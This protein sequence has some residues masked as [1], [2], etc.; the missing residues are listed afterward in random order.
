MAAG[1]R[2]RV[3]DGCRVLLSP[4]RAHSS[5]RVGDSLPVAAVRTELGV[6]SIFL[7]PGI[8]DLHW[9]MLKMRSFSDTHLG[10]KRP[11]VW[12]MEAGDKNRAADYVDRVPLVRY[13]GT[14][15]PPWG[16]HLHMEMLYRSGVLQNQDG[17][18]WVLCANPHLE[19]SGD[20]REWMPELAI[21]WDYEIEERAGDA[22]FADEVLDHGPFILAS[23]YRDGWYG[24]HFLQHFGIDGLA[25]LLRDLNRT[26]RVLLTGAWWDRPF[27]GDLARLSGVS[28]H[29]VG[30][31]TCPQLL[32]ILRRCA[33]YVGH[34]AGNGIMAAHFRR[35]TA[36]LWSSTKFSAP[37]FDSWVRP[38]DNGTLYRAVDVA[39]YS[40]AAEVTEHLRGAM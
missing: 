3:V 35:P 9:L 4:Y 20:F 12:L 40:V 34:A 21:D 25:A 38:E 1:S 7:P 13:R 19:R 31:T 33:G 24:E 17:F 16:G 27:L 5:R 11:D 10:G 14:Y 36:L 2:F 26:C 23:F 39:R 18:D 29:L 15:N 30:E 28:D 6:P 37:L 8:G 22:D 32:S